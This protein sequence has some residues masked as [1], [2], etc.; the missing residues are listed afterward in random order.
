M[1]QVYDLSNSSLCYYAAYN[2][3]S[4]LVI[5]PEKKP[6]EDLH[7]QG[8]LNQLDEHNLFGDNAVEHSE[9][10][11]D[12]YLGLMCQRGAAGSGAKTRFRI[13]GVWVQPDIVVR[14]DQTGVVYLSDTSN[15]GAISFG[16]VG[17]DGF[18][19]V[20]CDHFT[21]WG[22]KVWLCAT[23]CFR[24]AGGQV[25]GL[26]SYSQSG[27]LQPVPPSPPYYWRD[28]GVSGP[29]RGSILGVTASRSADH[30]LKTLEQQC[31]RSVVNAVPTLQHEVMWGNLSQTVANNAKI[32]DTNL[33]TLIPEL[34]NFKQGLIETVN[35]WNQ[36]FADRTLKGL[37]NAYLST[38]YGSRLT[39]L[40]VR[41]QALRIQEK[42]QDYERDD[43]VCVTHAREYRSN[44]GVVYP[45]YGE[46]IL[47]TYTLKCYY[48]GNVFADNIFDALSRL[49]LMPQLTDAWDMVPFSFVVDWFIDVQSFLDDIDARVYV[50]ALPV[51][52]TVR[53]YKASVK[54]DVALTDSSFFSG[55]YE[56][57]SRRI[58]GYLTLPRPSLDGNDLTHFG[59]VPEATA[60]LIQQIG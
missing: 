49:S 47:S 60:L 51:L 34:I 23:E 26:I 15:P 17:E 20:R 48:K 12:L 30:E 16:P 7:Y 5:N 33:V 1:I 14:R 40:D 53:G 32:V 29:N 8:T 46:P 10:Y 6:Y 56:Y 42:I 2:G 4:I 21:S 35:V 45:F 31:L 52:S 27:P 58:V 39:V 36:A 43:G 55:K 54:T 59:H 13:N 11:G 3:Y 18:E 38:L 37:S 22:Q 50:S 24:F 19:I 44:S 9:L 57:Y 41:D 28:P 25:T